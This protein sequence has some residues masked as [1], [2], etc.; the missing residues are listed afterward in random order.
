MILSSQQKCTKS[1][2]ASETWKTTGLTE[3]STVS[4]DGLASLDARPSADTV[5]TKFESN[6]YIYKSALKESVVEVVISFI[7]NR[8]QQ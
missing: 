5:L 8:T 4:A 6:I 3:G 1:L 7:S 2:I